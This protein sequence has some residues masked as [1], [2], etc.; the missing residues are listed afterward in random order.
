MSAYIG[1]IYFGSQRALHGID[2]VRYV[3]E[4]TFPRAYSEFVETYSKKWGIPQEL[5][6]GI[7]RA[8]SSY[9]RDAISPVG[10]LGLMQ[11][12]PSTGKRVSELM[13]DKN[14]EGRKL[15]E[16]ETAVRVGS[17]YLQRLMGKFDQNVALTAA[18]YNAGPHRVRGWLASFGTLDVDEFIE[19]IP[20]LETRN[21][22]KKVV[23][24]YYIYSHLYS[25]KKD[26]LA[27]LSEP[28]GLRFTDPVPTKETWDEI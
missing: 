17:R 22:V 26:G 23:S 8:E 19:H 9:K 18:S 16:P 7:M 6:W 10:A 3:W 5:I 21:Y 28:L 1:Q 4:Y 24:N 2:G 13:G 15:L 11:V 20:F 14:F 27:Y 12:M 25:K